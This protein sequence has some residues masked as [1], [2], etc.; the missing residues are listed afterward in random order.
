MNSRHFSSKLFGYNQDQDSTD[1][2][3]EAHRLGHR[4]NM[5]EHYFHYKNIN[6]TLLNLY[7][8]VVHGSLLNN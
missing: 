5:E 1:A 3:S 4:R 6:V 7:S 2:T 8:F